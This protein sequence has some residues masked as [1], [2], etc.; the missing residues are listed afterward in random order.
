ME[1]NKGKHSK[2]DGWIFAEEDILWDFKSL[3]E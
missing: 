2:Q 3:E 1:Q